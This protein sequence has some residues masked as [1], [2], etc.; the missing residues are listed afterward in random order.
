MSGELG[1]IIVTHGRVGEELLR[2]ATHIMGDKLGP[3]ECVRVPFMVEAAA[4][5]VN[6]FAERRQQ[7]AMAVRQAVTRV[8]Q[9]VGVIIFTDIIGGTA[10]NVCRE[11]LKPGEGAVV[12]GVNLPMLLKLPSIR[13]QPTVESVREAVFELAGRSRQGIGFYFP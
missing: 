5:G 8:N 11:V 10:F 12:S 13:R 9:G 7:I 1:C 3:I 6:S 2:V 4:T